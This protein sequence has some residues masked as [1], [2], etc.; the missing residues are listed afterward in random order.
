MKG[1]RISSSNKAFIPIQT[2]KRQ[3]RSIMSLITI[4]PDKQ[5]QQVLWRGW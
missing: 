5:K 1:C 4:K 2:P 3:T